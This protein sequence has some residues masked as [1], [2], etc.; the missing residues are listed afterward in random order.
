M[1]HIEGTFKGFEDYYLYYQRWQPELANQ[2]IVV[3]IHGLGAHSGIL[4][5]IV[6]YLVPRGYEVYA[7]DLRGHGRSPGQ[8]GHINAWQEFREDLQAFLQQIRRQRDDAPL[9]LWGHSL[10]GTIGLDYALRSPEQIQGLIVSAPALSHI[11]VPKPKLLI[12]QL[13]ST[14][15]PHFSLT[16]GLPKR[17]ATRNQA[18]LVADLPDPLRHERGSARLVTEFF[19]TVAWLNHHASELRVPLLLLHGMA[20]Q[21]TSPESSRAFFQQ[22][23][24]LD[25]EH[26]EYPDADHDLYDDLDHLMMF[27]D[28]EGWLDHH[29][30]VPQPSVATLVNLSTPVSLFSKTLPALLDDACDRHPNATAFNQWTPKGWQTQSNQALQQQIE[31]VALGLRQLGLQPGDRVAFLMPSNVHFAMADLGC[32]LAQLVDVPLDLTQTLEN[33]V[34]ALRHSA[35]KALIV[36]NL[37]LLKELSPYLANL[38]T[39]AQV[40]V[41]EAAENGPEITAAIDLPDSVQVTA[42]TALQT[43][44]ETQRSVA[45]LAQLRSA[46][47]PSDLATIIYIPGA[48]G[49]LLGVTLTHENIAGNALATFGELPDLAWGDGESALTFLPLTHIF[50]RHLLYGHIYHGHSIYFSDIHHF[51][52]H[53]QE[54]HP[55]VVATVPLLLEKIY[56][57]ICDRGSKLKSR[58]A[59]IAFNWALGIAQR[60]ELGQP[61]DPLYPWL[62]KLADR[63]VLRHWRSLFGGRLKYLLSGGAALK[64]AIANV[65]TAAGIPILQGYGLTQ[66]GGVVCF[67]RP[68]DNR[69]RS[70]GSPIPGVELAIAAD[71][72][73]LVRGAYITAGYYHHPM[74]TAD[75]I[76]AQGWLHTGDFGRLITAGHL[77]IT[78]LKKTLFKLST[79]KYIAPQPIETRLQASPLIAYA[80]LVGADRKFCAALIFPNLAVLRDRAQALDLPQ[81]EAELLQH[82]CILGWYQAVV[83]A[84]NCHLPYWS[85]VKRFRLINAELTIANGLLNAQQEIDR[86]QIT[87]HFASELAAL[88]GEAL[89]EPSRQKLHPVVLA[90]TPATDAAIDCPLPTVAVCPIEAQSLHPRFT[91]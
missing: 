63:A 66:S 14:C 37:A 26:H 24:L 71:Q 17:L 73:V 69:A 54:I 77:Q 36:S 89:P 12:G 57:Q 3:L 60:Y 75:L 70:V 20:D 47:Q 55:T 58:W 52:K 30:A 21:V 88:Y 61:T 9:I 5:N 87:Q 39:L 27:K 64:P 76:D 31:A 48:T 83:D 65:L 6:E 29:V 59:R 46:L 86:Y 56:Q 68:H 8:R 4:H 51:M 43:L 7:M 45:A 11:H 41:S 81:S 15:L 79:G 44:G 32:L 2:A 19:S 23:L 18:A 50:A 62:L 16:T 78:G 80:M 40:I 85:I 38:P 10:G 33:M 28:V 42:L 90:V 91:T 34:F 74:A 35:A 82:P 25:K 72:E 1:K 67:N 53:L 22:V 84:A 13:L 49:E